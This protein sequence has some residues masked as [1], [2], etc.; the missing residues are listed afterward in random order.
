MRVAG[1]KNAVSVAAAGLLV[2]IAAGPVSGQRL[3]EEWQVRTTAGAEA[4]VTGA[5]AVFWNPAQVQVGEGAVEAMV[6]DLR[7]PGITGIE[8]VAAAGAY[9]LDE[10][11]VIA[12]GYEH[13]GVS[14][15]ER[16]TDS[17]DGGSPIDFGENRFGVAASHR[18][19]GATR[20]GALMRYTRLPAASY[21]DANGNATGHAESV[22]ALGVGVRHRPLAA[23]PLD[24]AG[25][26]ATEGAEAY[27]LA[28]AEFASD[29]R[30]PEWGVRA[31]YGAAGGQ[32]APG[33]TH[34]A[35]G[36]AEWNDQ[37]ELTLG[38]V[39]EPDGT[40]RSLQPVLGA[41]LRITRYTL[42]AVREQLPNEF[43]SAYS[44]RFSVVF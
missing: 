34:R 7:G 12:V 26:V 8:G 17:P 3:L 21:T 44:F 4:M 30:W 6:L 23:L 29:L 2:A 18:L 38:A 22:V 20:V 42:G 39:S 10:R 33:I 41:A 16:T 9:V 43:G 27:W 24:I 28:G 25:M 11:T 14:G 40:G 31:E 19:G 13:V 32:L 36:T 1:A 37:V 5:S 35:A 15:I